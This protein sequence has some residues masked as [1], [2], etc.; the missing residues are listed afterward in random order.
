[1]IL[2]STWTSSIPRC[3]RTSVNFLSAIIFISVIKLIASHVV[4]DEK[5]TF[6][7]K[8]TDPLPKCTRSTLRKQLF[9]C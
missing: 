3:S 1:M 9:V 5:S 7:L 6:F 8:I 2:R 4:P